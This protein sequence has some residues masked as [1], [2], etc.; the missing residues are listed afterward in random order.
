[1]RVG[2]F[3]LAVF[4]LTVLLQA[5]VGAWT[6]PVAISPAGDTET[7]IPRIARG[8]DGKMLV[9]WRRKFPDWRLFYRERSAAG[10]WGP[11]ETVSVP[12]SERPDIIEDPLGRP[13][14]FY[15]GTGAG[16]KTDL[17]EA[18]RSSGT[19]TVTQFTNTDTIDEDYARL[20]ID[21]LGRI[22]LVY[23]KN[24]DVYYRVWNGSWSAETYLGRCENA[25][26]H[27]PDMCVAPDNTV[28]VTWQNRTT[29]YYRKFNGSV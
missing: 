13:H 23:T 24:T 29:F 2:R 9:T 3:F 19:W 15:A 20:G 5:S 21:S 6:T 7:S 4:V 26:Y 25:Y 10:V 1:M 16:G 18:V 22:H 8:S 27:R 14:M 11:V 28:H 17:F 12:W